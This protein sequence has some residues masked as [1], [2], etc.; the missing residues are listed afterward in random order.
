MDRVTE[1]MSEAVGQTG[2]AEAH[3][4]EKP[5]L[6]D[7]VLV[8]LERWKTLLLIP[9]L[10]GSVAL[11]VTFLLTPKFTSTARILVPQGSGGGAGILMQQLGSLGGLASA[12]AG[13]KNPSDQYVGFLASRTI[14]DSLIERFKLRDLYQAE[15]QDD[16]RLELAD[17]TALSAGVKDGIIS[18]SVD[19]RDPQRAAEMANAYVDELQRMVSAA[20]LT[21]AGQRRV[22]FEAEMRKAQEQLARAETTLRSSSVSAATL[23]IEPRAALDELARLRA[24]IT[25]AELRL[26]AARG[27]MTDSNPDLQQAMRELQALRRQL[28]QAERGT[29]RDGDS[30][31]ED[32]ISRYRDFKYQ[33]ALFEIVAKQF[34]LARLDEAGQGVR[35]QIIDKAV[36][37]D[38]RSWP[39]RGLTAAAVSVMSFLALAAYLVFREIIRLDRSPATEKRL[40]R[41]QAVFRRNGRR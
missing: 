4:Q 30:A 31:N 39:R 19:D 26:A 37:A 28:A 7:L 23:R 16:A 1:G 2:V 38:R 20:A 10:A 5:A 33:E 34:E 3:A 15:L 12:A 35:V 41:L 22:F 13:L 6:L 9:L 29:S 25:A 18:V 40:G 11:G 36:P 24:A 8:L 27:M 21:E 32:Y 17:N 14:A